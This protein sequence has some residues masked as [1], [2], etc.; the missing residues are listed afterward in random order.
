MATLS[1]KYVTLYYI[2]CQFFHKPIIQL[3]TVLSVYQDTEER[4]LMASTIY[5]FLLYQLMATTKLPGSKGYKMQ[6]DIHSATHKANV[7]LV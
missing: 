1:T 7:S 6:M 2:Y 5:I 4:W 3:F